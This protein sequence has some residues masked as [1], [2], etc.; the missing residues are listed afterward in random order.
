MNPPFGYGR[1][2]LAL[3]LAVDRRFVVG[4]D[5]QLHGWSASSAIQ[6]YNTIRAERNPCFNRVSR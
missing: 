6:L 5:M 4:V 2:D 3:D 1:G